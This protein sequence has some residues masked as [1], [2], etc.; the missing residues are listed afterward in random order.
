MIHT[1]F[2]LAYND[3]NQPLAKQDH[4][5]FKI[6]RDVGVSG[7]FNGTVTITAYEIIY[8]SVGLPTSN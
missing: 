1:P 2:T 5:Y 6:G 7:D 3:A 4:I 8:N